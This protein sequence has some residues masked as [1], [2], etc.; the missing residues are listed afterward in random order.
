MGKTK[1]GVEDFGGRSQQE[2]QVPEL[3][4][5]GQQLGPAKEADLRAEAAEQ[6]VQVRRWA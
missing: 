4:D 3:Q 1:P 2:P 6:Q 5:Q